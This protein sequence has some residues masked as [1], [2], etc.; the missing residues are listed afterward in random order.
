MIGVVMTLHRSGERAHAD[1]RQVDTPLHRN[2]FVLRKLSVL[3]VL[4]IAFIGQTCIHPA[5]AQQ[6]SGRLPSVPANPMLTP[7]GPS[8]TKTSPNSRSQALQARDFAEAREQAVIELQELSTRLA[9]T[10]NNAFNRGLMTLDDYAD[11]LNMSL[12]MRSATLDPQTDRNAWLVVLS[13]HAARLR[14]ANR[15]IEAFQQPAAK[16]WSADVAFSRVLLNDA[17]TML[18]KAQNDD[19]YYRHLLDQRDELTQQNLA[20]RVADYKVGLAKLQQVSRAASLIPINQ[21]LINDDEDDQQQTVSALQGYRGA[22][23]DIVGEFDKLAEVG[24]G[25]GRADNIHLARFE[26]ARVNAQL[27][28]P[29]QDADALSAAFNTAEQ[30]AIDLFQ[31]QLKFYETGTASLYDLSRSW[32]L[33]HQLHQAEREAG[34]KVDESVSERRQAD[35]TQLLQLADQ[36]VDL[37]GRHAADVTFVRGMGALERYEQLQAVAAKAKPA[38]DEQ[39]TPQESRFGRRPSNR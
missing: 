16:G 6:T 7:I 30:S 39:P 1:S 21:T 37:R 31:T 38:Y 9:E 33:R 29:A 13:D 10:S 12:Q 28:L 17:E 35:L 32:R 19:A 26:L 18:A 20:A 5:N 36:T 4:A 14:N 23:E 27:A 25:N 8:N 15:R 2:Q 34:L 3:P 11:Q 22:L 24:A